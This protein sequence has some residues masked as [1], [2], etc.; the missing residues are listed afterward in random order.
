MGTALLSG[1]LSSME[2]RLSGTPADGT[3]DESIPS[4]FIACVGQEESVARLKD[5]FSAFRILGNKVSIVAAD[6][7]EA[8]KKA[9]VVLLWYVPPIHLIY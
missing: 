8:V 7:T 2:S 1:V 4:K 6:N 9:D 3:P 5:A